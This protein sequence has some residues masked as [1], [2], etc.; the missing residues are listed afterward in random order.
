MFQIMTNQNTELEKK[1][2]EYKTF[3]IDIEL[4]S[5]HKLDELFAD[6]F[7]NSYW[8]ERKI[9]AQEIGGMHNQ[10]ALP[11]LLDALTTDPF[12]MVRCAIIQALGLIGD[13]RA[14]P[15]LR[16]IEKNDSF[17]AVRSYSAMIS[18]RISFS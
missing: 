6:L 11:G 10:D 2:N 13:S 4:Q 9:A 8:Y 16:E 14:I 15:T 7:S 5:N 18:G 12:W 3:P 17:Q 1:V